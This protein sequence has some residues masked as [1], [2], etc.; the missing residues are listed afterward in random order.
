[1]EKLKIKKRDGR[2]EKFETI[3]ISNAIMKAASEIGFKL[4][5]SV[6][7][8]ITTRVMQVIEKKQKEEN[9]N[10]IEVEEVQDIIESVLSKA[11]YKKDYAVL[12]NSFSEYRKERTALREKKSEIMNIITKI[13][14]ET[15]RDNANVG[16]NFSSKL[17]IF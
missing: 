12:K 15:D 10:I 1:M 6:V 4:E 7:L 11:P 9:I 2:F 5:D 17:L 16:N 14:V 13:G 8:G 3:K